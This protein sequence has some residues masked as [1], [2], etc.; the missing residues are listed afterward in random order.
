MQVRVFGTLRQFAGAKAVEVD[1]EP[2]DTVQSLLGRI[3]TQYPALREKV[4]D[5]EGNLQNSIH[6]LVNGRSTR[7]LDGLESG[8]E[9]GDSIALFPA[10]GGG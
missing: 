3:T 10:V 5:D 9:K 7:Y 8:V 4:F 1:V 2:G 6:I